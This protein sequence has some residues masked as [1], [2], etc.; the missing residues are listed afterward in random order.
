MKCSA[1]A[2]R[3]ERLVASFGASSRRDP[4]W[5]ARSAIPVKSRA[6][7]VGSGEP[8]CKPGSVEGNHSSGTRIA[9]SLEQ[10]TRKRTRI[11]LRALFY[12]PRGFPI[13]PCSRWGLPCHRVLPPARCALTAPFHPYRSPQQELRKLR[14]F[15]FCCTFRGL[16]P[17][18]RYL[19]PHPPEPGL[20]SIPAEAETAITQPTPHTTIRCGRGKANAIDGASALG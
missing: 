11:A 14:R 6:Q 9:A 8:A 15:A 12:Q 7:P 13:W 1:T 10:P 18:R 17:P 3:K 4:L 20:S 19:A 5:V 16:A 2:C